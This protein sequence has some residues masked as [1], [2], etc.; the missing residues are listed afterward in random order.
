MR[1]PPIANAPGKEPQIPPRTKANNL[2]VATS[3]TKDPPVP[4]IWQPEIGGKSYPNLEKLCRDMYKSDKTFRKILH[5][6]KD[7]KLFQV[8]DRLIYYH[9]NLETRT[10][11]IP[12]SEFRG[13][14]LA[15]IVIDQVHRTVG[16]MGPRVT[17][18]YAR[19]L[20]WWPTLGANVKIFCDSCSV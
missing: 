7:H 11:C 18:N 12:H 4:F 13:R 16:H 10:L 2:T 1:P 19:R 15:E 6:P 8:V 5:N 17:E 3:T 9:G 14:K 20:F